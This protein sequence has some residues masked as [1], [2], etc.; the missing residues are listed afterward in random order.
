M[1]FVNHHGLNLEYLAPGQSNLDASAGNNIRAIFLILSTLWIL[2]FIAA[3][4]LQKNTWFLLAVGAIGIVQNILVAGCYW[5][6][7]SFG[8]SLDFVRVF[9][10]RKVM[11]TLLEVEKNYVGLG[12]SML[13]GLIPGKVR[14][15]EI[16]RWSEIESRDAQTQS[17]LYRARKKMSSAGSPHTRTKVKMK[18]EED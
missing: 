5:R 9:G 6:P 4:G 3:A 8:M 11:N 12:R 7:E 1:D 15:D 16:Q 2:L 10:Q 17:S 18:I 13:D 14:P